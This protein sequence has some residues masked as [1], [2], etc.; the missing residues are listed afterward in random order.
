M[1]QPTLIPSE[2][3]FQAGDGTGLGSFGRRLLAEG[4]SWFTLSALKVPQ[5]SN[6]LY[7]LSFQTS[8]AIVNCAY[9]GDTLKDMVVGLCDPRF[10]R[11]L[12][13]PP[14]ASYWEGLL[15]SAGG[16][17]LICA[18]QHRATH[19]DGTP[20][21]AEER[22]L[23]TPQEAD[24]GIAGPQRYISEP[25]WTQ[26]AGFLRANLAEI[27]ARRDQGP[28]R[29]RPL[30]L[31]TYSVPVARPAGVPGSSQGWLYP[32]LDVYGIPDDARQ[33]LVVLLFQRLRALWLQAASAL[34]QVHV[35]DSAAVPLVAADPN[36]SGASGDWINEIHL[37]RGGYAK[38]GAQ[39]GP[40]IEQVLA[41]YP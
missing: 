20:S 21:T 4:D 28:S 40:W 12:R 10:D 18:L 3:L 9:P 11:L 25:G 2:T 29:G 32:A 17:D 22:L 13:V 34:P 37:T 33:P 36:A 7:G 35:F 31:H 41:T 8:T 14:Y 30:M 39:M 19:A 24:P 16:N 26:L 27:V 38:I 5:A 23:L 1:G 6:L 15:L